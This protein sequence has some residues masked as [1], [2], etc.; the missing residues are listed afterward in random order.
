MNKILDNLWLGDLNDA[1]NLI[2]LKQHG[3]THILQ[4][5]AGFKPA[6]PEEFKYKVINV[7][8]MPYVNISRHFPVA[9]QFM[10]EGMTEGNS[11][12]VHCYAGVSRSASCIIALLM[13]E[14]GLTFLEGMSFTRKKRPIVFPNFGFQR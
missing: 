2:K 4:V 14:C 8:D 3:I 7:L 6:Y 13:Q 10:K 11:V 9:I 12:L 5:A 1:S